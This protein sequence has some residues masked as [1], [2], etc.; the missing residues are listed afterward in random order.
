MPNI[1]G[2]REVLLEESHK[3]RYSIH[4]GCTKMY[5]DL[6]IQ[7]WWPVMKLDAARY[8][9]KSVTCLQVKVE[10]Q[11]PYGSLQPLDIP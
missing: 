4:P 9:E 10:H 5:R 1:G 11:R 6:K 8:V 7:Y 3:S 2:I